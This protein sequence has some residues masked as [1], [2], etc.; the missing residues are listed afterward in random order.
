[1]LPLDNYLEYAIHQQTRFE[2]LEDMLG[3][4]RK[5]DFRGLVLVDICQG[6]KDLVIA[7]IPPEDATIAKKDP[8]WNHRTHVDKGLPHCPLCHCEGNVLFSP[9]KSTVLY[10]GNPGTPWSLKVEVKP[11]HENN[12]G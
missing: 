10:D 11:I 9:H 2:S 5:R 3:E 7:I 12:R 1:M 4:F 6:C 8:S